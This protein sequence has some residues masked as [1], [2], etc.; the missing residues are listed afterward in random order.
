MTCFTKRII[1]KCLPVFLL[2]SLLLAGCTSVPISTD[3]S[4][5]SV[6]SKAE[7]E[8][9]NESEVSKAESEASKAESET[10]EES[11]P[12]QNSM[13][14]ESEPEQNSMPEEYLKKLN[15]GWTVPK[16]EDLVGTAWG[17]EKYTDD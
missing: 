3:E 5:L 16:G 6:S 10:V 13:P 11:E 4:S 9:I 7:S 15:D 17:W 2:C 8:Q 12:E 14:E 1:K